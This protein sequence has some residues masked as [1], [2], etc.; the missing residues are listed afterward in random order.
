MA[1]WLVSFRTRHNLRQRPL[2]CRKMYLFTLL[3]RAGP[4]SGLPKSSR[5]NSRRRDTAPPS[6]LWL[7]PPPTILS[8]QSCA[9]IFAS[10]YGEGEAPDTC[11]SFRAALLA[12]DCP[13]LNSLRYNVFCLGDSNYEQFCGFGV[14]LDE[15]LAAL[16]G[17]RLVSRVESDVEVDAP[18]R[19]L[20]GRL[21]GSDWA[22]EY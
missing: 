6:H 2:S 11:H 19:R 12:E 15:R 9:V 5:R 22:K 17:T 16:G 7:L 1:S 21:P 13:R 10:T 18:L 3:P 20:E 14:E 4:R 8:N